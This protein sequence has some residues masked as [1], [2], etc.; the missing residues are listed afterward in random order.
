MGDGHPLSEI[1]RREVIPG[2]RAHPTTLVF[3]A[4]QGPE[5]IGIAICLRGFSTFA[6]RPLINIHDFFVRP[7]HRGQGVARAL[8]EAT[9]QRARTLNCCKLTLEVLENNLPARRTYEAAGF[10][11]GEYLPEAGGSLFFWKKL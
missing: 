6:A 7:E 11:Q 3:L 10:T 8:L 5:P 9:A 1:A 2:L 4:Y